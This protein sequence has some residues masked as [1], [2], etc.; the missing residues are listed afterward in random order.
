MINQVTLMKKIIGMWKDENPDYVHPM[1]RF[2]RWCKKI[3][4][5]LFN[6]PTI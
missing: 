6:K 4:K 1:V 2:V 3:L 5:K